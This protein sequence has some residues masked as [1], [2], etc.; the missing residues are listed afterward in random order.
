MKRYEGIQVLRGLAVIL[1]VLG[2]WGLFFGNGFIGVDV[3]F[4]ISGYVVTLVSLRRTSETSSFSVY[5]FMRARFLRLFPALSVMVLFVV[6]FQLL[7]YPRFEWARAAE[8]GIWSILW[9]SN[10]YSH[11]RLGDYFG[12]TAG[13][14]LLLHTWSLSVEFQAYLLLAVLFFWLLARTKN[15]RRLQ[16]ALAVFSLISLAIA[17]AGQLDYM[18]GI[19]QAVSS[20][21]SPV[22]RFYQI[23][24]G[25]ILA[26]LSG[27]TSR[28]RPS[29]A[30][31]GAIVIVGVALLPEDLIPWNLAGLAAVV[32]ATAFIASVASASTLSRPVKYLAKVGDYSYSVY[33]WHWPIM[34]VTQAVVPGVFEQFI[35]GAGLTVLFS[36]VSTRFLELPFMSSRAKDSFSQKKE[37]A[38]FGSAIAIFLILLTSSVT[39]SSI[40]PDDFKTV[41]GVPN[42]DVTQLGFARALDELVKP[43]PGG[44]SE[45]SENIGWIYSCYENSDSKEIDILLLG[46]SHA[47][48]L[49]PGIVSVFPEVKLRYLSFRGGYAAGNDELRK[50]LNYWA[51]SGSSAKHLFINSFWE[52]EEFSAV[53]IKRAI[54]LSQVK[55]ADTFIFDDVPNFKISP[56][57]C[58]YSILFPIPA[59]CAERLDG[60]SAHLVRF[61]ATLAAEVASAK[62]VS[63]AEYFE[64]AEG[65]FSMVRNGEIHFRDQNH[66]N[67]KG[68][69]ALFEHL[70]R[71]SKVAVRP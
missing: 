17:M 57:R 13:T 8:E 56:V 5:Q 21:Y 44:S 6:L 35:F 16:L 63:S 22:A 43:C 68:S 25:A 62:L 30:L 20:Y 27:S 64:T 60:F 10:V 58:K 55:E 42:G 11:V 23:G 66:L 59:P 32:G 65:M 1:V 51:A 37:G 47:A 38:V 52:I 61:H 46:N 9:G 48:H 14:S 40:K 31:T 7:Y 36:L 71:N 45:F 19:W 4:V 15:L 67:V 54:V 70:Q 33:L 3:F 53:E 34:V 41:P 50:A 28:R 49:I 24:A 39:W 26:T 29:Y 2:H 12:E 69:S 18:G